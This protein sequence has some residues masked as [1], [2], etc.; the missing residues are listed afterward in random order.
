MSGG[1]Y[2]GWVD[3]VDCAQPEGEAEC[4]RLEVFHGGVWGT[5]CD[6]D[7]GDT[8]ATVACRQA[9]FSTGV[10]YQSFGED[11]TPGEGLIWMDDVDCAG[12]EES[13]IDC[14]FSGWG[15]VLSPH[16][17]LSGETDFSVRIWQRKPQHNWVSLEIPVKHLCNDFCRQIR[18]HK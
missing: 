5:V 9:G 18:K 4:C 16:A 2:E 10:D 14:D 12:G 8:D 13:L 6:D 15:C 11:F 17:T 7:F 3:L 1:E